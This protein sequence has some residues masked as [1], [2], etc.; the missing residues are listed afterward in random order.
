MIFSREQF[1]SIGP[2]HLDDFPLNTSNQDLMFEI[3]NRL[4]QHIQGNAVAW[5]CSD[6]PFREEAFEYLCN[7]LLGL[8]IEKYYDSAYAKDYFDN[9]M[10]IEVDLTKIK[11]G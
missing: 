7:K 11:E 2:F 5:G 8:T 6:T 4:P 9:G 3:F 1:D 10:E